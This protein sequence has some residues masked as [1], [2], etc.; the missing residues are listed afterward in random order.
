METNKNK[1][2]SIIVPAY[3]VENFIGQ[4]IKSILNQ[5]YRNY[6]IFVVDD[7]S[8]DCTGNIIEE[9]DGEDKRIHACKQPNKGVSAARNYAL[10]QINGDYC[11]FVDSDDY[12]EPDALEKLVSAME[13]NRADWVNCQY[14]RVDENGNSLEN[15]DFIKGFIDLSKEKDRLTFIRDTLMDYKVGYEIWD[16]LYRTDIIKKNNL[17]FDENCHIGEDLEFNICYAMAAKSIICIED[18]CYNY[19]I[20][21]NSAM[22]NA[23]SLEKN[24]NESIV[25][26]KGIQD[27]FEKS[28]H[29]NE[30]DKF[31][32]LFYKIM[33]HACIGFTA[34]ETL[35]VAQRSKYRDYYGKNMKA[36][37][38]HKKDFGEF[39]NPVYAKTIWTYGYYILSHMEN[40]A[41]GKMY[42]RL[43]NC[44]RLIRGRAVIEKWKTL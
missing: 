27:T 15:Y 20:R 32:Q 6:E 4:C 11:L 34:A 36:A 24:F 38:E 8:Y 44:Y 29:D 17:R 18:R 9:F 41:W 23:R 2:V 31:Y 14:K 28:F 37:L 10:E 5:S 26:A 35:E 3:N 30:G 19:R 40:N 13:S 25:L 21:S 7:G 16:K 22:D 12:L 1:L 39:L 42:C 33:N 43:Y